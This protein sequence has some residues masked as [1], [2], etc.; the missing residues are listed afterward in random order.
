M[1][2]NLGVTV[3]G[4]TVRVSSKAFA[5]SLFGADRAVQNVLSAGGNL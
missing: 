2:K 5:P 1:D 4:V 3:A